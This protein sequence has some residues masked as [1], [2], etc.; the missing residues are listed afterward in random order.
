MRVLIP[1]L[2]KQENNPAFLSKALQEA[3]EAVL[4]VVVDTG[5]M[6]GKFGFAGTEIM[7]GSKLIEELKARVAEK[8]V[9]AKD[10]LEWGSTAQKIEN[11]ARLQKADRIALV[12][13]DNLYFKELLKQLQKE[14]GQEV[15]IALINIPKQKEQENQ[16][17]G[18][19]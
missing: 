14:I 8:G 3:K 17:I 7:Q 18:R 13:Q 9:L 1:L 10:L 2:S 6:A 5:E 4:L 19:I 15:E 11:I 12:K 16:L